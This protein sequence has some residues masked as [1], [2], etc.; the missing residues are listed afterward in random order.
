MPLSFAGRNRASD[1]YIIYYATY[2]GKTGHI[3]IAVDNYK[4]IFRENSKGGDTGPVADTVPTGELS[5]YDLWPNDDY[6]SVGRTGKDIPA[7]YYKLPVSTTEEITLNSLYDKGIP[8]KE[9]YPTDGLLKVPTNWNQDQW[10]KNFLD[11][12][13]SA[14]RDFNAQKFNCTDFVRIPLETL[15]DQELKCREFILVGW[16]STPNKFYRKLRKV[17]GVEVIKNADDKA[18][19]SFIGQRV[20]Y[21]IFH[22]SK[23]IKHIH[24]NQTI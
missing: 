13:V 7:V 20:I 17:K 6:F 5:Y 12:M 22:H 19:R 8:H 21:K 23:K 10:V 16:S 1:I 14:N 3:G 24:E 18:H 9:N 15:L 4:I 11:S 2:K